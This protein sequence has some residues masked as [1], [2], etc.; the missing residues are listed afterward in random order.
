MHLIQMVHYGNYVYQ[1]KCDEIPDLNVKDEDERL[2]LVPACAP[3]LSAL[4]CG[5][6]SW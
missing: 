4:G 6:G 1:T 3:I 5:G 2:H